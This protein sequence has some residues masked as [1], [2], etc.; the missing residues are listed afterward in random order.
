MRFNIEAERA[1]KGLTKEELS[2][3]LGVSLKTYYNWVN[4]DMDIPSSSLLKMADMFGTSI[5]YLLNRRCKGV[6]NPMDFA[7]KRE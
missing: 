5:D 2:M 3:Q 4:K 7:D 6:D 1:R